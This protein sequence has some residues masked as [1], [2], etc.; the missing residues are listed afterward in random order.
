M[1]R[2][3]GLN[4]IKKPNPYSLGPRPV[5]LFAFRR[6]VAIMFAA[7]AKPKGSVVPLMFA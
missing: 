6:D 3:T 5:V 2:V 7:N 1:E 4:E